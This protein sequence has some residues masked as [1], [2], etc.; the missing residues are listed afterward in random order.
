MYE[1][2]SYHDVLDEVRDELR[3]SVTFAIGAGVAPERILIDPGLGFAKQPAHSYEALARLDSLAELGRPI[4]VGPSRK[5]FL[6]KPARN[7]VPGDSRDWATAA[8]VTAAILSGAHV[9]RVHAV[10]EMVQL[11]RVA[12]EIRKYHRAE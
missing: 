9:V 1:H 11:A 7:E 8:A 2:A 5:G 10:G 3:Q 6:T 4:L 12:D